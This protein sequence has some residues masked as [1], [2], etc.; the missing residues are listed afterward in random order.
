VITG[1]SEYIVVAGVTATFDALSEA[2]RERNLSTIEEDPRHLRLAFRLDRPAEGEVT[3]A[4]CAVLDAGH[5]L[6]KMVVVCVDEVDGSVVAPDAALDGLFI[7]V[8]HMLHTARGKRMGVALP[9]LVQV[10]TMHAARLE[11]RGEQ[12]AAGRPTTYQ[13]FQ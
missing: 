9:P 12:G 3:K 8:E 11:P 13:C 7:H 6:S 10:G 1:S 5:G 4:L 2:V